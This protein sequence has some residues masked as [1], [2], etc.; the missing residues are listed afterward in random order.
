MLSQRRGQKNGTNIAYS[1]HYFLNIPQK[2]IHF[3]QHSLP[4]IKHIKINNDSKLAQRR[5]DQKFVQ[6]NILQSLLCNCVSNCDK[7]YFNLFIIH[8]EVTHIHKK[9]IGVRKYNKVCTKPFTK[10]RLSHLRWRRELIMNI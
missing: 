9:I 8:L 6:P 5:N 7:R 4:D 1:T 3:F 2:Q 10:L